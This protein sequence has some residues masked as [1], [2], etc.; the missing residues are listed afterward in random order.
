[1]KLP[2]FLIP[3]KLP[4]YIIIGVLC[5]SVVAWASNSFPRHSVLQEILDQQAKDIK[6]EYEKK[7]E[8]KEVVIQGLETKLQA[9]KKVVNGLNEEIKRLG[10]ARGQINEPT[11]QKETVDRFNKLG[12]ISI[13]K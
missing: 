9:S 10:I 5:L 1:M 8:E 11:T 7:I 13:I 4:L 3:Y 2:D 12:Y 6:T